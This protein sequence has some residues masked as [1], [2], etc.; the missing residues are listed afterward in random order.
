[1]LSL[2]GSYAVK[3]G[4]AKH[5]FNTR[6]SDSFVGIL[7]DSLNRRNISVLNITDMNNSHKV[8]TNVGSVVMR[9][10]WCVNDLLEKL[11]K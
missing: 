2:I 11:K 10:G 1:M 5:S 9:G 7:I 3:G 8:D 4:I 6:L